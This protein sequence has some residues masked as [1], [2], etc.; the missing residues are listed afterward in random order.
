MVTCVGQQRPLGRL[1]VILVVSQMDD[2]I[3][4]IL[5]QL[6]LSHPTS[7]SYMLHTHQEQRP[8]R[9]S[10]SILFA[11]SILG[12]THPNRQYLCHILSELTNTIYGFQLV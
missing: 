4:A 10:L 3:D 8:H 2:V 7:A 5:L 11:A 9:Y 12:F 6:H 1:L